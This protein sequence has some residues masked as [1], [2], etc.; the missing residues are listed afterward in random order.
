MEWS[1]CMMS[2]KEFARTLRLRRAAATLLVI[3]AACAA[4]TIAMWI[5]ND[6]VG[7]SFWRAF[8]C[9]LFV[10]FVTTVALLERADKFVTRA[11]FLMDEADRRHHAERASA[12][13]HRL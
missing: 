12:S 3:L 1:T 11:T 10:V 2:D 5:V 4:M 6:L 7:V 13:I 9:C 8:V